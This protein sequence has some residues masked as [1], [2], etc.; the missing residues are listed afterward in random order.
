[1]SNTNE[2]G[3][4]VNIMREQIYDMPPGAVFGK[5]DFMKLVTIYTRRRVLGDLCEEEHIIP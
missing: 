2:G 5:V 4:I 1:M 3:C